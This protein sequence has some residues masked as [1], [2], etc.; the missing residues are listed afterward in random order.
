V[1]LNTAQDRG[2]EELVRRMMELIT[3]KGN[4]YTIYAV[5][6]SLNPRTGQPVAT[7]KMKR[8]FRIDP[9]FNPA[10]PADNTFDPAQAGTGSATDRFR[11]PSGFTVTVLQ[12]SV[13]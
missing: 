9:T 4:V 6:Q 10:L 12:S 1:A 7:Q 8:T 11:R 2:R 3:T 5:G 13:E